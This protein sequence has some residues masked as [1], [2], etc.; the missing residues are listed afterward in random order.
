MWSFRRGE[1]RTVDYSKIIQGHSEGTQISREFNALVNKVQ[2]VQ[3]RSANMQKFGINIQGKRMLLMS[4]ITDD[5]IGIKEKLRA[6]ELLCKLDGDFDRARLQAAEDCKRGE[7][8]RYA[9]GTV[10]EVPK[11]GGKNE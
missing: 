10:E 11:N 8:I 3:R 4:W 6:M 9:W 2:D 7:P 1:Q 5:C